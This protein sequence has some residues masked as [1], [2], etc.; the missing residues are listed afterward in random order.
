MFPELG[1]R[2]IH[3]AGES[4]GGKYVPTYAARMRRKL[5]SIILVD[6]FVDAHPLI[7]GLYEH[8][9]V[10][11]PLVRNGR[12]F[13]ATACEVMEKGY[14][15]CEQGAK[16]CDL[17]Y[18]AETCAA[19]YEACQAIYDQFGQVVVEG[20]WDPY[21]DRHICHEPPLCG[22]QGKLSFWKRISPCPMN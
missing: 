14:S 21:D 11:T 17:T 9:C 13:N 15:S 22:G 18:D 2:P 8:L 6:P 16:Q 19:G 1:D 4:F 3:I 5:D 20:G 10:P 7:L 12:Q